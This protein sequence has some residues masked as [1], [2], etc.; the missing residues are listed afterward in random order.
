[1]SDAPPLGINRVSVSGSGNV[2]QNEDRIPAVV[3]TRKGYDN[4]NKQ[5]F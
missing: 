3:F 4:E 1:M 2:G 5:I